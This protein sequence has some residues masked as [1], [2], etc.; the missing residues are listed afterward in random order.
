LQGVVNDHILAG[1]YIVV[2]TSWTTLPD[3]TYSYTP[4]KDEKLLIVSCF[5]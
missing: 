2:S 3:A 5:S 4:E 1:A